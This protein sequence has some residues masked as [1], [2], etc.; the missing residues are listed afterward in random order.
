MRECERYTMTELGHGELEQVILGIVRFRKLK[1]VVVV[2]GR[3]GG[4]F[5]EWGVFMTF[6]SL[7]T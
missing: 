4:K 5:G 7:A 6:F 3:S 2:G 1:V